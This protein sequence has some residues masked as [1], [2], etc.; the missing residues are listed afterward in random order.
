MTD[1]TAPELAELAF[2]SQFLVWAA[3]QWI[4]ISNPGEPAARRLCEAFEQVGAPHALVSLDAALGTLATRARR[5]LD[6][7]QASDTLLGRDERHLIEVIDALQ[8]QPADRS[9]CACVGTAYG[10]VT[11]WVGTA[12]LSLLQPR[13]ADLAMQLGS[14][15]LRVR[16]E[17]VR[18][19]TNRT[20]PVH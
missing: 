3:R 20:P 18:P 8:A 16:C 19:H 15:G 14:A 2:P 1:S 12:H 5:R 11:D 13:L 4:R 17:A 7:R 9:R 10:I 6:F